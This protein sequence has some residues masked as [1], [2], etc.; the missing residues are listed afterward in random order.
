MHNVYRLPIVS[1]LLLACSFW[2][3]SQDAPSETQDDIQWMRIES[4]SGEFSIEIP[5]SNNLFYDEEGFLISEPGSYGKYQLKEMYLINAYA[6]GALLSVESY[7]ASKSALKAF[8]SIDKSEK[9]DEKTSEIANAG[10]TIRQMIVNT[11]KAQLIRQYIASKTHI[12]LITAGMRDKDN[13]VARRFLNS[14]RF[15]QTANPSADPGSIAMSKLP[16]ANVSVDQDLSNQSRTT[17]IPNPA[18]KTDDKIITPLAILSKPVSA[19]THEGADN[20]VQGT[21]RLK[22]TLSKDGFIPKILIIGKGLAGGL[23]RQALFSALRIKFL[24]KLIDQKPTSVILTFDYAF[25]I[26]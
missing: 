2:V 25:G 20:Y 6:D 14:L 19:Y 17:K 24:P 10:Y 8:Y 3:F 18:Q 26:R 23:T 11:E 13:A 4:D 21:I 15:Y 5:K 22:A 9:G 1:V 7:K 16:R 12:Y